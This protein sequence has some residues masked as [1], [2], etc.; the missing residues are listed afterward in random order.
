VRHHFGKSVWPFR[1]NIIIPTSLQHGATPCV[2][3]KSVKE[4]HPLASFC[5]MFSFIA[6]KSTHF[7]LKVPP[8]TQASPH[9]P[10][11][12]GATQIRLASIKSFLQLVFTFFS[13]ERRDNRRRLCLDCT[14][15]LFPFIRIFRIYTKSK[16]STAQATTTTLP[17]HQEGYGKP[18]K[19]HMTSA[20]PRPHALRSRGH[21]PR[22]LLGSRCIRTRAPPARSSTLRNVTR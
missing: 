18:R 8:Y 12:S 4:F 14:N 3:C 15:N 10:R 21:L 20:S 13:K 1:L 9:V 6:S 7:R 16:R 17:R 22:P 5:F 19:E 11:H 2:G